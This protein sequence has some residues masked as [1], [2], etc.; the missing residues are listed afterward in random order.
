LEIVLSKKGFAGIT[1]SIRSDIKYGI[2]PIPYYQFD[3]IPAELQQIKTM[4]FQHGIPSSIAK[5]KLRISGT[6][7]CLLI[8]DLFQLQDEWYNALKDIFLKGGHRTEEGIKSLFDKFGVQSQL[9]RADI[10]KII[11]EYKNNKISN[12]QQKI[13]QHKAALTLLPAYDTLYDTLDILHTPCQQCS[14]CGVRIYFTGKHPHGD[15]TV[16]LCEKCA[17]TLNEGAPRVLPTPRKHLLRFTQYKLYE[18]TGE[19]YRQLRTTLC[20]VCGVAE[21]AYV[22]S[23]RDTAKDSIS[24]CLSCKNR[25]DTFVRM[26]STDSMLEEEIKIFLEQKFPDFKFIKKRVSHLTPDFVCEEHKK[27]IEVFGCKWHACSIHFPDFP[28]RESSTYEYRARLF[29]QYGYETLILWGHDIDVEEDELYRKIAHF[30]RPH[31]GLT[32]T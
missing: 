23:I 7:N 20:E 17:S 22:F 32:S 16:L 13:I 21:T 11:I 10:D 24:L 25:W 19:M 9:T 2:R 1:F 6:N 26:Y 3:G 15:N 29:G 30:L 4:L 27:I 8:A 18:Q 12:T 14:E 31:S 5:N 28:V